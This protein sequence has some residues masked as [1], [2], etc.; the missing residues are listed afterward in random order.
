MA[1]P[2]TP[3]GQSVEVGLVL[4]IRIQG[5][6]LRSAGSPVVRREQAELAAASPGL[7]GGVELFGE[8]GRAASLRL[9]YRLV[10]IVGEQAAS[11]HRRAA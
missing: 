4:A 1:S 3:E 9:Y 8:V 5:K 11:R 2:R 10:L 7:I 6:L